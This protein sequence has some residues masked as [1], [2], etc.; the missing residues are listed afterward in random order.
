MAAILRERQ[1]DV[2]VAAKPDMLLIGF[3]FVYY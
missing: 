3:L 1:Q 2:P